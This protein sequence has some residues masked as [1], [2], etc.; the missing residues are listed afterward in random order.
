MVVGGFGLDRVDRN[1][2][3]VSVWVEWGR[4]VCD[5]FVYDEVEADVCG[6]GE[7]EGVVEKGTL[8]FLPNLLLQESNYKY[9]IMVT[10]IMK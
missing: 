10:S 7:I 2:V 6:G 4:C 5:R 8:S 1:I 9:H 3:E